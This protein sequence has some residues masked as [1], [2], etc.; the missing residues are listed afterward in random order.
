MMKTIFYP[1]PLCPPS[2]RR[3]EGGLYGREGLLCAEE[4]YQPGRAKTL[5]IYIVTN[6]VL[7]C[8]LPGDCPVTVYRDL[9]RYQDSFSK[10]H[11]QVRLYYAQIDATSSRAYQLTMN[12][13]GVNKSMGQ[14][15]RYFTRLNGKK[16][17]KN[18]T[19]KRLWILAA[20]GKRLFMN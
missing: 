13:N 9:D 10:F 3:G 11:Q 15:L 8:K 18:N 12:M 6:F 1:L 2:P 17:A 7:S 16:E 4:R 14:M 19:H 5:N 20:K